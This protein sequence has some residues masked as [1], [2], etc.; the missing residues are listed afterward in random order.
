MLGGKEVI[1]GNTYIYIWVVV[2]VLCGHM[3]RAIQVSSGLH[4]F[5]TQGAADGFQSPLLFYVRVALY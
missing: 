4:S 2:Q 1:Y 5:P 3:R